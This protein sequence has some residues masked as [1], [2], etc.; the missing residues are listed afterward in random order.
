M[1]DAFGLAAS[2]AGIVSLGLQVYTGV[3]SYVEGI[4]DR[5]AELS[6]VTRQANSL[7]TAVKVLQDATP[8]I[9]AVLSTS[10]SSL[11]P[12]LKT[13][14]E[15]LWALRLFLGSLQEQEVPN[16][17][18]DIART[19]KQQKK[20]FTFP[21]NRPTLEKLQKKLESANNALQTSLQVVDL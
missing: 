7:Q 14:E 10:D 9:N 12:A 15:E 19:L 3:S 2:A 8:R 18:S 6:A 11:V 16:Q 21:F 13:V 20:K 1:A 4:K 17:T 5:K